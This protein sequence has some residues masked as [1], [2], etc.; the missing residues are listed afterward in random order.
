MGLG[1]SLSEFMPAN[2]IPTLY[3]ETELT[4]YTI[5]TKTPLAVADLNPENNSSEISVIDDKNNT[6]CYFKRPRLYNHFL[7][8]TQ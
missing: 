4:D 5:S 2:L 7:N 8:V 3:L 6:S 1:T